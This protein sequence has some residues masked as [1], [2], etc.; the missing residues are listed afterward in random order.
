MVWSVQAAMHPWGPTSTPPAHTVASFELLPSRARVLVPA[1]QS[2]TAAARESFVCGARS[3]LLVT[4]YNSW[5]CGT[6][7]PSPERN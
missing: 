7:V 3:L 5:K 2:T 6:A 4:A 1:Q